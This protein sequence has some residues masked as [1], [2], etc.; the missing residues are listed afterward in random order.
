MRFD[1]NF[2][3]AFLLSLGL[4][5]LAI[6]PN[7]FSGLL[8]KPKKETNLQ[9]KYLKPDLIKNPA[10]KTPISSA[11]KE[12]FLSIPNKVVAKAKISPPP[13]V[14]REEVLKKI[15]PTRVNNSQVTKP[16]M[17][18]NDVISIKKRIT[19]P[20]V[21]LDKM[22][23]PTYISYYQLVREKIKRAAYQN[24]SRADAGDVFISFV[25]SEDGY[26]KNLLLQQE[27]SCSNNYLK[28]IAI[29]SVKDASPFPNFPKELDYPQ[30]SFNVII[31]FE[32]EN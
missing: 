17:A 19:L 24:Y 20:P 5:G 8:P 22:D 21:D 4:H 16:V 9:V 28:E 7:P 1:K 31:S 10:V 6:L 14:E 15:K 26:L 2:Q 32:I 30:L 23:N 12:P 18:N 13:F 27:K 3:F 11:K 29:R 25:I